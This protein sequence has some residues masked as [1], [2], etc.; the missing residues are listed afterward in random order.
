MWTG[1]KPWQ[2]NQTETL[3]VE[4][5]KIQRHALQAILQSSQQ[6]TKYINNHRK[7]YSGRL[8]WITL[9]A[10]VYGQRKVTKYAHT[11]ANKTKT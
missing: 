7:K 6:N 8:Q 3:P 9:E 4:F 11:E 1:N 5:S 2:K 10:H